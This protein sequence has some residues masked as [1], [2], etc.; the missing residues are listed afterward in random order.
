MD[1]IQLAL[2]LVGWPNGEKLALNCVQIND[3]SERKSTQ[4]H[5]SPGQTESQV[6][7]SFQLASTCDSVWPGLYFQVAVIFGGGGGG[8]ALLSE[9]YG[10]YGTV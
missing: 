5:A 2:T 4:V 10:I 9:F 6:G 8:E 3:Q 7:P 1:V